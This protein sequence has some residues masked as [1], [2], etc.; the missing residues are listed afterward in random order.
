MKS[1]FNKLI[2]KNVSSILIILIG[3]TIQSV[4]YPILFVIG[5]IN[6][7]NERVMSV[8]SILA[9]IWSFIPL[10]SIVGIIISTIQI[11][12]RNVSKLPIIGLILNIIWLILFLLVAYFI[13]T[14]GV[15]V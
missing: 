12:K 7:L 5:V 9:L 6:H 4:T 10:V 15:S 3:L 13:F 2:N 14:V 8:I 1:F 11:Y